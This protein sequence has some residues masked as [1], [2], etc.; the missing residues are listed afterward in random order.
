MTK[1]KIMHKEK[2]VEKLKI[3]SNKQ[4]VCPVCN[5]D[6]EYLDVVDAED[7]GAYKL[8]E[9]NS[10]NCTGREY[11]EF[12]DHYDVYTAD[13]EMRV[14]D[15]DAIYRI[16]RERLKTLLKNTLSTLHET[17]GEKESYETL[18]DLADNIGITQ[19]EYDCIMGVT[20]D[21]TEDSD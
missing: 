18:Y 11:L 3:V 10:C 15:E 21:P 16:D 19:E 6:I 20:S 7:A 2:K 13:G 4:G 9:C 17:T 5:N 14:D 12:V 1:N 8:W